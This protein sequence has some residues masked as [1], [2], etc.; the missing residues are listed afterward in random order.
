VRTLLQE[1]EDDDLGTQAAGPLEDLVRLRGAELIG[2]IEAEVER[3]ARF[4]RALG[5]IWLSH[6]ELPADVLERVVR[7]S[8]GEIRPLPPL[9]ELERRHPLDGWNG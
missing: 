4:R 1:A 2:E 5:C 7:A 6:G 8:G 3:D 9:E